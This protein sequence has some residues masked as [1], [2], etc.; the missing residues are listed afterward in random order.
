MSTRREPVRQL[1]RHPFHELSDMLMTPH[2]AAFTDGTAD[3]RWSSVAGGLDRSAR[4]ELLDNNV[5]RT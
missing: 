1:S 2:R 5:V 4:S 3:R